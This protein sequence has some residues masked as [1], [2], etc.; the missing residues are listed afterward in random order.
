MNSELSIARF[1]DG[2]G[3]LQTFPRK[4]EAKLEVLRFFAAKFATGETYSEQAVNE[5]I[6]QYY[7]DHESVRR[8]LI[9]FGFMQRDAAT[10]TYWRSED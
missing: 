5:E 10:G 8:E 2:N 7:S 9:D 1:L 3:R 6:W 4:R